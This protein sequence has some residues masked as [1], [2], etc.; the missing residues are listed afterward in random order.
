[1]QTKNKKHSNH[2]RMSTDRSLAFLRND[3]SVSIMQHPSR[4]TLNKDIP[5]ESSIYESQL[6][7]QEKRAQMVDTYG[8][9]RE[10]VTNSKPASLVRAKRN[11]KAF[12]SGQG[13]PMYS[14]HNGIPPTFEPCLSGRKRSKEALPQLRTSLPAKREIPTAINSNKYE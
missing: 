14:E 7:S 3:S 1:M 13:S 10:R 9:L 4:I 5:G 11:A 12:F 8:P 6:L 2:L